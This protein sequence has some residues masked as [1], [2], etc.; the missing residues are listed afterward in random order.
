MKYFIFIIFYNILLIKKEFFSSK[1][2]DSGYSLQHK[3]PACLPDKKWTVTF[4]HHFNVGDYH[5]L[6]HC[7]YFSFLSFMHCIMTDNSYCSEI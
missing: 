2:I 4:H 7:P 6:F 1:L 5:Q 3:N